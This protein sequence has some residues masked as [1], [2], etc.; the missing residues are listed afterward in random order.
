MSKKQNTEQLEPDEVS[1][2]EVKKEMIELQKLGIKLVD[3][4]DSQL[5]RMPLPE[6]LSEAIQSAKNITKH[7]GLKRQ[8]KYIGKLMRHLD[9]EP[10]IQAFDVIENGNQEDKH[11]FHLKEQWRSKLLEGDN[12]KLTEFLNRYPEADVQRLRQLIRNYKTAKSDDKKAQI[13]RQV[14]KIISEQL[15]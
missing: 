6:N 9:P 7:G 2:T 3:L 1:K 14:F 11:L 4:A 15:V 10:I 8:L 12:Q 13:A 5:K